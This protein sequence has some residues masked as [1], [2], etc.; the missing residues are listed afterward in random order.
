MMVGKSSLNALIGFQTDLELLQNK[1]DVVTE[2]TL[3]P[4]VRDSALREAIP[5]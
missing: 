3:K 5:R 4:H 2:Q 1:A